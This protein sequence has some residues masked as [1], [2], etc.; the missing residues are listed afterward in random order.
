MWKRKDLKNKARKVVKKNYWTA[1]VVC[2]LLALFSGEFGTSIILIWQSD[3]SIDPNYV[4]KQEN[5]VVNN[6]VA[7]DKIKEVQERN[8]ELNEKRSSLSDIQLKLLEVLKANL[9]NITKSQ[10]YVLRIWDA[11]EL[12]SLKE[13][14]LGVGFILIAL[15][16]I[17]YIILLAEPLVV[18]S[19]KYFLKAR[20]KENTKIG[21]MKEIFRKGNWKNVAIIM[22]LKDL[23]NLLWFLTIIGGFIKTYEYR[24]IPYILAD[25]PQIDKKEAFRLSKEMMRHNKWKTFILDLSFIL[26]NML[27][28]VTFGILNILYVNPYKVATLTELYVFLKNQNTEELA[29]SDDLKESE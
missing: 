11:V 13:T 16:A 1:I 22:F 18:S 26:W 27:S 25:N 29:Q 21:I 28:L 7:Q 9:N 23:Y 4:M 19:K 24:M 12:F 6:E 3:D 14:G 17:V 5:I 20:E 2:F 8:E 15:I 10:K